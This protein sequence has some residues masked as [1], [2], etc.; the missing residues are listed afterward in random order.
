MRIPSLPGFSLLFTAIWFIASIARP[1][2]ERTLTTVEIL[3]PLISGDGTYH[4]RKQVTARLSLSGPV[5]RHYTGVVLGGP[6]LPNADDLVLW[7]HAE[8]TSCINSPRPQCRPFSFYLDPLYDQKH[9]WG[10]KLD[11]SSDSF[12]GIATFKI[13]HRPRNPKP[14]DQ[15]RRCASE[16]LQ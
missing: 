7:C 15:T 16:A 11:R 4:Y 14:Q 2:I 8:C 12:T 3:T 13:D 1:D 6:V 5:L 10:F 9:T